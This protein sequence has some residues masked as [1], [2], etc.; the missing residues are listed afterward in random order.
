MTIL[1]FEGFL[2]V[3]KFKFLKKLTLF[4]PLFQHKDEQNIIGIF[5]VSATMSTKIYDYVMNKNKL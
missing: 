4:T 1:N 3:K 2:M 5:F